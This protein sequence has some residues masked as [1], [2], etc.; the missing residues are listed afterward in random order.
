[1]NLKRTMEPCDGRVYSEEI[2]LEV[3]SHPH[4]KSH[5][6]AVAGRERDSDGSEVWT[7]DL[8]SAN[9]I[10]IEDNN[11]K[12]TEHHPSIYEADLLHDLERTPHVPMLSLPSQ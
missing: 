3:Y 10:Q 12:G 6:L 2:S 7:V 4:A 11:D 5:D 8:A 9:R 1:M